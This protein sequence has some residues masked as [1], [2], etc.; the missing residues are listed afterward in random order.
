MSNIGEI[1]DAIVTTIQGITPLR[2]PDY[3]WYEAQLGDHEDI[4]ELPIPSAKW[5]ANRQFTVFPLVEQTDAVFDG[6]AEFSQMVEISWRYSAKSLRNWKKE[7]SYMA[8]SDAAE[9]RKAL[10]VPPSASWNTV[11]LCDL[12]YSYSVDLTESET[13]ED[14]WVTR[15]IWQV[16]YELS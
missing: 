4:A 1:C 7:L 3:T 2:F 9:V 16:N 15:Q 14:N 5:Q 6:S 13:V 11:D 10:T 12:Q 8:G